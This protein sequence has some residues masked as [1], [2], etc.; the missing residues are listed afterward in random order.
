[1]ISA[2][3]TIVNDNI[4]SPQRNSVPLNH[5]SLVPR[6]GQYVNDLFDLESLLPIA[7]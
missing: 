6:E 3:G 5:V 4:P 2:D 1:M 7:S